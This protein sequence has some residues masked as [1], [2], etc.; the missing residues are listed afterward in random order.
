MDKSKMI[1]KGRYCILERLGKGGEG[2]VYLARDMELGI[3]WAVKEI[4]LAR[5][6]EAQ[7]LL[8]MEH[9]SLPRMIDYV[10]EE[11][12]C[13]L[14]MEY[15][16]GS[17]LGELLRRG[18]H[19]SVTEVLGYAQE[20]AEILIYL[21]SRKPPVYYGD[22]KP[23]NLILDKTGKIY[24]VDFGCAVRAYARRSEICAGTKGYAPPE[25]YDGRIEASSDVYALGKTMKILLGKN[26]ERKLLF[27]NIY[28]FLL[29]E[30]C[31]MKK[32]K[33]RY[34]NVKILKEKLKK[35][36][37]LH[38]S[39]KSR[40]TVLAVLCSLLFMCSAF[41]GKERQKNAPDF[42][43][44][45]TQVTSLYYEKEFLQGNT[46]EK[47]RICKEAEKQ[48]QELLRQYH[49]K[50]EQRKLL[51][52]LA[53]N[54]EYQNSYKETRIYYE[55]LLLYDKTYAAGYGE[56]GMF[57]LRNGKKKASLQ[58]W[59]EFRENEKLDASAGRNL[60]LWEKE[61][62]RIEKE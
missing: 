59:K 24:L 20:T 41:R 16:K 10:E 13:Y 14:V 55:Q 61:M 58:L 28:L 38:R 4:P 15:I 62:K 49:K 56:Y 12:N 46:K 48:F 31:C 39:R 57:L 5:K 26:G 22:L 2:T 53:A 42:Y 23:D 47:E 1:L 11:D 52:L 27:Q 21:H 50:E 32:T 17:S 34:Q 7:M 40:V 3:L 18:R 51:L 9:S 8:E 36:E 19:F 54:S 30:K 25:L 37:K 60:E 35:A 45:L 43:T 29:I 33:W 6:K 44:E